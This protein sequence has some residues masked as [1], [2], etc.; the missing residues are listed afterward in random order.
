MW[1]DTYRAV[2]TAILPGAASRALAAQVRIVA[3]AA[4]CEAPQ[5]SRWWA[6][7]SMPPLP[8]WRALALAAGMELRWH[9]LSGEWQAEHEARRARTVRAKRGRVL[10]EHE[11]RG[12]W[13]LP[14][15]QAAAELGCTRQ[16]V[17]AARKR[18]PQ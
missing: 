8:V 17:E 11:I 1:L 15:R 16:A 4:G 5:P 14:A 2:A 6:G 3:F 9:D 18:W 7:L 10:T 12:T 13:A